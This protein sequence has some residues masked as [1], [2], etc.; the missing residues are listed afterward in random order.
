LAEAQV[1]AAAE[2]RTLTK[3]SRNDEIIIGLVF[4]S[5]QFTNKHRIKKLVRITGSTEKRIAQ[6]KSALFS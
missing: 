1:L 4:S 3:V 5:L 6:V 2:V